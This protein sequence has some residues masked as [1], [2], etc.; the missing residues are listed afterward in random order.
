MSK[1]REKIMYLKCCNESLFI[2]KYVYPVAVHV[3][4]SPHSVVMMKTRGGEL[5]PI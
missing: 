3:P 5:F 2:G 4:L 1:N